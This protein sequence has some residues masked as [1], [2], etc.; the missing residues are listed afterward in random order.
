MIA[1]LSRLLHRPRVSGPAWIDAD[2]LRRRLVAGNPVVLVDVRERE[3]FV[4]PPGH[5]PGAINVPMAELAARM[6][7]LAQ[8]RQPVVVVC[9]TDRRSAQAAAGLLA[10]G[11]REVAVLRGGT[12]EWHRRGLALEQ[13]A[14]PLPIAAVSPEERRSAD[15]SHSPA[16]VKQWGGAGAA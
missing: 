9:K 6:P 10:A 13:C 1:L 15:G 16:H 2:E 4:A 12:D 8:H 11:L 5:L 7:E 3:E 14:E